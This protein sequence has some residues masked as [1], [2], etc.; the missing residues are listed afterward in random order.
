MAGAEGDWR[1][2]TE[3]ICWGEVDNT[4]ATFPGAD[5][6]CKEGGRASYAKQLF[7]PGSDYFCW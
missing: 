2:G 6:G 7:L 4:K 1:D 5:A 3:G